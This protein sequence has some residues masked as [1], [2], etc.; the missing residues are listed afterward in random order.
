MNSFLFRIASEYYKHHKDDIHTFTFVFPNRRAGLFFQNYLSQIAL[1]PL[2]SPE[3]ITIDSIFQQSSELQSADR[4]Y[5]LFKLYR[6]Y[7]DESEHQESFDSF[8]FWAEMLL[9]DFNDVDKYMID[10]KQL[11]TNVKDYKDI[12]DLFDIFSEQQKEAISRFLG[13]FDIHKKNKYEENFISTWQV[14]FPIYSKFKKELFEEKMGYEGMI[15]RY[16]SDKLNKN[17]R[18]EWF[19]NKKFVFVGFNALNPCEKKLMDILNKREQA[20]FYWD[21]DANELKDPDNPASSFYKENTNLFKSK[22]DITVETI[23]ENRNFEVFGI[24]SSI[25]QAKTVF[26]ILQQIYPEANDDIDYLKTAVVIPDENLM[27]PVLYS[28]PENIKK[29]NVTMGYPLQL[30]SVASLVEQIFELHKRKR[31]FDGNYK[32][33][34]VNV[35]NILSHQLISV[36]CADTIKIINDKIINENLTYIH[37]NVF[38][39]NNLLK[40]IFNPDVNSTSFLEYLIN[41]LKY[42]FHETNRIKTDDADYKLESSFLYQYYITLNRISGILKSNADSISMQLDT[43]MRLIKQLTNGINIPFVGEPLEGLQIIGSLETRGLDFENII[44]TS[45]NEGVYPQK[46]FTNSFIPYNLRKGFNLPTY[47]HLDAITSYN[48]YRL[49]NRAKNIYFVYDSR[50]DNGNTGEVSRFLHQLKYHYLIDIKTKNISFEVNSPDENVINITKDDAIVNKLKAFFDL[51]ENHSSLSP[52]SINTYINCPLQFYLNYVEKISTV[53][54]ISEQ[55]EANVFG[56]IF[57]DVIANIY[58][59]FEGKIL[60]SD[61]IKSI[62]KNKENINLFINKAFARHFF[63]QPEGSTVNLQ[64]NNLLIA[65]VLFKYVVGVLE[66]DI[67]Q[68]PFTYIVGEKP[69]KST[70]STKYG[71][72]R[73]G[74]IIDRIDIKDG[75]IRIFDY[76]TGSG[77]LEFEKWGDLFN[78]DAE[79]NKQA[80]HVLQ[81]F[82]YGYLYKDTVDNQQI[83]PGIIYVRDIFKKDFAPFIKYKAEKQKVEVDN[84]MDFNDDFVENLRACVEEIFD[85]S[86]P[87]FQTKNLDTCKYCNFKSICKR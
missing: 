26:S 13:S 62:I 23:K 1:K 28:I 53:D 8:V 12:D 73:I 5:L 17:E 46:S 48:F 81:T 84:Y 56:S 25:G 71:N 68:T 30:T 22:Y 51:P 24:P 65:S 43:L 40:T 18:F 57:H 47:E 72:V 52:S 45:F 67:T 86:V 2:F 60:N 64:G 9:A 7:C 75:V 59:P 44:I 82:L 3:I 38:S 78:H 50:I 10:A 80:S 70:L 27:L 21:Y 15:S 29:I 76:K 41:I 11:F 66:K 79:P 19:D 6:I 54:E 20:D 77:T 37:Q 83:K 49:I 4:L 31:I 34:H 32:F 58:K 69:V 61:D 16:V 74:G 87:F 33:Y 39:Q 14:L 55:M 85:T 63:K 35:K 42:L 36:F